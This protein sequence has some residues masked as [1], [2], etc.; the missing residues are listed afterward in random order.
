MTGM[1]VSV[2]KLRDHNNNYRKVYLVSCISK[3]RGVTTTILTAWKAYIIMGI[4]RESWVTG[5]PRRDWVTCAIVAD[6]QSVTVHYSRLSWGESLTLAPS[7]VDQ[8]RPVDRR[9]SNSNGQLRSVNCNSK[10][11][12][13]DFA[14]CGIAVAHSHIVDENHCNLNLHCRAK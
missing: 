10:L 2:S 6:S 11:T 13:Y 14:T 3:T 4:A 1:T 12:T 8:R 9:P 5:S 7:L